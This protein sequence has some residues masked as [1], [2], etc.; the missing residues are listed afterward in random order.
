MSCSQIWFLR[1]AWALGVSACLL[2]SGGCSDES[3]PP[4]DGPAQ[5]DSYQMDVHPVGFVSP[6]DSCRGSSGELALRFVLTDHRTQP[7][8]AGERFGGES[9]DLDASSVSL[10]A[11]PSSLFEVNRQP[12]CQ[13]DADCT[14]AQARC[15]L[16]PGLDPVV[17]AQTDQLR[18]CQIPDAGLSTQ[19]VEFRSDRDSDQVVGVLVENSGSLAGWYPPG[20]ER[21][22][23]SDGDGTTDAPAEA[24]KLGEAIA[25]D[26]EERRFAAVGDMFTSWRLVAQGGAERQ[27]ATYF[28]VWSFESGRDHPVSH[29]ESASPNSVW[30]DRTDIGEQ[31]VQ[32]LRLDAP[33]QP[34]RAN[35]YEAAYDVLTNAY[36]VDKLGDLQSNSESFDKTLVLV[37]DGPDGLGANTAYG[38]DDVIDAA[39]ANQVR[40]FV[41]QLD[42]RLEAPDML[43]EDP[44]Y[45]QDQDPCSDDSVC[46]GYEECRKPRGFADQVDQPVDAPAGFDDRYCLPRRDVYGRTGPIAD[47]ARL[48]CATEG[49]YIYVASPKQLGRRTRWLPLA[50]DALWEARVDSSAIADGQVP[51]DSALKLQ[52]TMH[53]QIGEA[54][55]TYSF[56]QAGRFGHVGANT[57]LDEA[58]TRA[59]VFTH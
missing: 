1:C 40:V 5:S 7:I 21:A 18:R 46:K 59:V 16:A 13:D 3:G 52:A 22:Y 4:K 32:S 47:Y 10:N 20:A 9:V 28:G 48:G 2:L 58:D 45:W 11:S 55:N 39:V 33:N 25:T 57:D 14:A 54:A 42:P 15:Q 41:V 43:R 31:A 35:I 51:S 53:V 12:V 29:V 44:T 19:R 27:V 24:R 8:V 38:I 36:S 56:W 34:E 26:P 30:T 6:A 23:D 17:E 37:V 50:A 49:G